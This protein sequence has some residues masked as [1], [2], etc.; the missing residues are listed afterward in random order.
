MQRNRNDGQLGRQAELSSGSHRKSTERLRS[1]E[2]TAVL[3]RMHK[4]ACGSDV[5]S[6]R[7][8]CDE[9]LGP[10]RTLIARWR[11]EGTR[12]TAVQTAPSRT[13]L[14]AFHARFA[15]PGQAPGKSTA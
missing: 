3:E 12:G 5:G 9:P 6:P 8:R 11:G 7:A 14:P 2:H 1:R 4:S 13:N 10:I 15:Q